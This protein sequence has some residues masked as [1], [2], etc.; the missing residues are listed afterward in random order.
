MIS[1]VIPVHNEQA[2]IAPLCRALRQVLP[3]GHEILFVD[4]G[5][6][7]GTWREISELHRAGCARAIRFRR[8]FGKT[9]ALQHGFAAARGEIVFTMDGDLQDDPAEVP[10][11]LAKLGEGYDV[12]SG[13]KKRRRDPLG[14]VLASRLFNAVVSLACG[15]RVHDVNC[16]FK[17]YRAEVAR[18]L[19]LHGEMHRFT[20]VLA[21]AM[22]FRVT[23]I[24]VTHHPRR[25]GR[26][27]YGLARLFKGFLDLITVVLVTRYGDRPSHGFGLAAFALVAA[28]AALARPFPI[29]GAAAAVAAA[30]LLA[31]GLVA[32]ILIRRGPAELAAW[33][34]RE[35]LD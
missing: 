15:V 7:D 32:E 6:T 30:V 13:W 18:N 25:H 27:H 28:A 33:R 4:D 22:G 12:V 11:F 9:L 34:V 1:V 20:P 5:S 21:H 23:E 2:T 17:A 16:G 31:A 24:V 19:R 14:K 29:W 10:R 26:S 35:Q 3:E 8:N